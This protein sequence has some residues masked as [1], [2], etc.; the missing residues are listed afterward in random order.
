VSCAETAKPIDLPFGLWTRV[1]RRKHKF[2]RIRQVAPMY[3]HG[4][5]RWRHLTNTTEPS[6]FGGDA[7]LC[8]NYFDHLLHLL[9]NISC[10]LS[11]WSI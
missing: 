1:G 11:T 8:Q 2:S 7:V 6:V 3:P 4:R 5:A 10:G 9:F